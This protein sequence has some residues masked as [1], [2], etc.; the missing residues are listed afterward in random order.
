MSPREWLFDPDS[1][2]KKIPELTK[3]TTEE[4]IRRYAEAHLLVVTPG[5]IFVFAVNSV[6]L[7]PTRS[8]NRPGRGGRRR[9]GPRAARSTWS[10]C[11]ARRRICAGC[12]T[13]V[14]TA[15]GLRSILTR[16]SDTNCR[17]SLP[18]IFSACRKRRS[19]SRLK[20]IFETGV[21]RANNQQGSSPPKEVCWS[22]VSRDGSVPILTFRLCPGE[23]VGKCAL[24]IA[25]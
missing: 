11:E 14:T 6:I 20:C 1:G 3:F 23:A 18:G 10:V 5:S 9:T 25:F 19:K 7:M 21:Q 8:R 22:V 17:C 16:T 24:E 4:R 12:A 2:G 15:G 13:L